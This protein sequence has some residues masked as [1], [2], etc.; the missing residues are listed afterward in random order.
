MVKKGVSFDSAKDIPS[1]QGKTILITG[2][3]LG[4]GKQTAL[5]LAKHN[6]SELW[7]AARNL[8]AGNATVEEIKKAS[9]GV[10][11]HFLRLD[12]ASFK[13]VKEAAKTFLGAVSRLDIFYMNAGIMGGP[14]VTTEDGYE[15]QF[16]TNHMGHALLFKLLRPL[17]LK[18]ASIPGADVRVVVLS[19]AGHRFGKKEL[20][21]DTMK[22]SAGHVSAID[23][24]CHSKL[25]NV[26]YARALA[27]NVPQITCTSVY[28][29]DIQT[30]LF[31]TNGGSWMITLLRMVVVPLTSVSVEEGVKNQLWAGTAKGVESGEYYEP[32]GVTGKASAQACSDETA[33]K[34]WDW[35]EKE[36]EG[37]D[38]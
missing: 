26:L 1:L 29:G 22:S 9:P 21:F 38:I 12:L 34:L 28:P 23:K 8:Q 10:P 30:A 6:P 19:S 7:I 2:G 20:M 16:G 18:T 11:V 33:K 31:S 36:L 14:H 17:M 32:V 25:A 15:R 4:L 5:D 13:S 27:K 24:Y 3:N 37:H 35:T